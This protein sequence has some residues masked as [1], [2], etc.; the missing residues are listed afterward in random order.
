MPKIIKYIFFL[1]PVSLWAETHL[2]VIALKHRM[3]QKMVPVIKEH[4][5]E[6]ESLS[7]HKNQLIIQAEKER[8]AQLEAL[9]KKLDT[10]ARQLL[11]QLKR[12][13]T[14]NRS[15][16]KSYGTHLSSQVSQVQRLPVLEGEKIVMTF[17]K[18]KVQLL[19]QQSHHAGV[20]TSALLH[21]ADKEI[22][23]TPVI[24]DG[25]VMINLNRH[26]TTVID[27][28]LQTQSDGLHTMMRVPLGRWTPLDGLVAEQD[29]SVGVNA[30]GTVSENNYQW[31]IHVDVVGELSI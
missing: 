21:A 19:R 24:L 4:L 2:G 15:H 31:L 17:S 13:T 5:L 3:A 29:V 20:T 16:R 28:D 14:P 11:I 26:Q 23:I 22:T 27:G 8:L 18:E 10:P 12:K 30:S 7:S 1:L 9:I 6:K 25:Q